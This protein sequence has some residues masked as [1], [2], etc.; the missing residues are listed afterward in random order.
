MNKHKYTVL[1]YVVKRTTIIFLIGLLVR[2]LTSCFYF[3]T[4]SIKF[5]MINCATFIP[6]L[7]KYL[8]NFIDLGDIIT[9]INITDLTIINQYLGT[10][11]I[12][13]ALSGSIACILYDTYFKYNAAINCVAQSVEP[14]AKPIVKDP[15][16]PIK[17]SLNPKGQHS[18][19][20]NNINNNLIS[21]Q[22]VCNNRI[23]KVETRAIVLFDN[24]GKKGSMVIFDPDNK[25]T[26]YDF[27]GN[28]QPLL[29]NTRKTLDDQASLKHGNNTLSNK[30]FTNELRKLMIDHLQ[31]VNPDFARSIWK[32]DG[33]SNVFNGR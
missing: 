3:K 32:P 13:G 4:F 9:K 25:R 6:I 7:G 18:S 27:N 11:T 33:F 8:A 12:G 23:G 19:T 17:E 31:D 22:T 2:G 28:N 10:I 20:Q 1:M 21:G 30:M 14:E 16:I 15:E 5:Y 24:S 26:N 29:G